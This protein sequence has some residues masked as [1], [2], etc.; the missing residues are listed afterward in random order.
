[1][2]ETPRLNPFQRLK[3]LI[4]GNALN[5][6]DR[7]SFHSISLIA[8]FAWVGLGADGLSSSSYG[9]ENAFLALKEHPHLGIFVALATILT[10]FVISAS[11]SQ[12]I[13]LFPT[14][15][16]GYLVA[17]KLLNPT[18]GM[19]CG[20]ALLID[21][22]LTLTISVAAGAD[23][24]L[25]F[26][27][28][29]W[30]RYKLEAT[31][32]GI[33]LLSVLNLRGAKESIMVL[34]PVFIVFL[35]THAFIIMYALLMHAGDI[36]ALIQST[37]QD[38]H[39]SMSE[40]G[41]VGMFLLIMRSYSMGGST[42]TGIEAVSNGLPILREP[43]VQTG[44]RTMIYM[45][46]SL[47]FTVFG[48]MVAY[49]LYD[50]S[51]EAGKTL[52]A[53]L[54]EKATAAWG[55]KMGTLFV[56]ISLFSE[57]AILFAAAQ[58]GFMG[59]PRVLA[60]MSLD[61]WYP[62]KFTLLS[63]RLV[64]QNGIILMGAAAV[65]MV[66]L[67][68]GSVEFLSV[69]YVITVFITFVLSQLGMVRHWATTRR[70][71]DKW[72]RKLAVNGLGLGMCIF[73]LAAVTFLKFNEGGWLALVLT[74]V[75]VA[76]AMFVKRHYSNTAKMLKRMDNLVQAAQSSHT[77]A[78]S[79]IVKGDGHAHRADDP[80][81][82]PKFDP[83]ARTAVML[84]SGFNGLGLHT[85]F[86]IIRLFG[87]IY[88]NFVFVE[89]G[90]IDAGLYKGSD[91]VDNLQAHVKKQ[92]DGYVEFIRR[93]GYYG[94]G[95]SALSHDVVEG[96]ANLAPKIMERFPQSVF[97]MGQLVFPEESFLSRLFHNNV[98]FAVQRRLYHLGIP[99]IIMPVRVKM[100]V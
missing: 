83:K 17:S 58:A 41:W 29:D 30:Y 98:V 40:L 100:R 24:I 10:I 76:I 80:I 7:N 54:F 97:F 22:I 60:N 85:L 52:N 68:G 26:L 33:V 89:I 4:L 66:A 61:H 11:Y 8:F 99:F 75:L 62:T 35:I 31:L 38:T 73:I 50:V 32:L 13:E 5:P 63:D 21:Y 6:A 19:I 69:L 84:V 43:K 23:A 90:L 44:K 46:T 9:P 27:P 42:Y 93:H 39:Q 87:G 95:V 49:L 71:E 92:L 47:A 82:E 15:G 34:L 14:G 3:V 57:A 65:V 51:P 64:S 45:S 74:G 86:S 94:E 55:P 48:L 28:A 12:I 1:M 2:P 67:S 96:S 91:E 36:P 78:I 20:C 81:P 18:M 16:G 25:S 72:K 70:R 59:G 79:K 88:K 53:V 56:Q 77:G 37:A